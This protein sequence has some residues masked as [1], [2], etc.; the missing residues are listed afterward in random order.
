M[1]SLVELSPYLK[2]VKKPI[3]K[4]TTFSRE[5]N[6]RSR[7]KK[8]I[9][10]EINMKN[11]HHGQ[12][13]L[14]LSEIEF[15]TVE[16]DKWKNKKDI[17]LLYVGAAEGYHTEMLIKLFPDFEYHLYDKREFYD[18]LYDNEK[19]KIFNK[20]FDDKIAKT[21]KNKNV[22]F[23]CDIRSRD[24]QNKNKKSIKNQNTIVSQDMIWQQEWYNI[25][26]PLTALFKFRLPWLPGKTKYLDGTIFYQVWQGKHSTETRLIPNGL[27]KE[28]DN[29]AY[30]E[31][32]FYFNTET[33]RKFYSDKLVFG[34]K[35]KDLKCYGHSYD[36]MSEA[37]I[38]YN[39]LTVIKDVKTKIN[40]EICKLGREI[41][42]SLKE[43]G[44]NHPYIYEDTVLKMFKI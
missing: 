2:N 19:V 39:Y 27:I 16:Y 10:E 22:I 11:I 24:I 12:R 42:A 18:K 40:F 28:Y 8:Y 30:E 33:R 31:R 21:Y 36:S 13:K 38:L 1:K 3:K 32:L 44:I 5:L 14:L 7:K 43:S 41:S 37:L 23:I 25:I 15:L 29:T 9:K 26:K 20:Y 6:N 4:A 35:V 17:I 34:D